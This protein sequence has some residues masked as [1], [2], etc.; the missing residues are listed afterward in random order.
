MIYS[1]GYVSLMTSPPLTKTIESIEDFVE[2]GLSWGERGSTRST[3]I[4][5]L[6]RGLPIYA[7]AAEQ[8]V[9]E[10]SEE[11]RM[12]NIHSGKFVY[13]V[14]ISSNKFITDLPSNT[15]LELPLRVM[16]TCMINYYS[17]LGFPKQSPYR[18]YFSRKLST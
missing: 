14:K 10:S 1:S 17:T 15:T 7:K 6:S 16:K 9:L 11:E 13:F 8:V 4:D 18:E 12:R 2:Q 5:Q 3:K